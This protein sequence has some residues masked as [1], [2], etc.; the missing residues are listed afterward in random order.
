MSFHSLLVLLLLKL[1]IRAHASSSSNQQTNNAIVP[2][3]TK[4]TNLRQLQEDTQTPPTTLGVTLAGSVFYDFNQNGLRDSNEYG[5]PDVTIQIRNCANQRMGSTR[6]NAIGEYAVSLSTP[7]CYYARLDIT[8][9]TFTSGSNVDPLT[10][11]TGSVTLE[12]GAANF[13]YSSILPG[14]GIT[15]QPTGVPTVEQPPSPRPTVS[16]TT[17]SPTVRPSVS[18]TTAPPTLSP[19]IT[20]A[21]SGSPT[22]S[23][24]PTA[25][26]VK[27]PDAQNIMGSAPILRS[28]FGAIFSISTPTLSE[29]A[30]DVGMTESQLL[31][32]RE[33]SNPDAEYVRIKSLS[34][35]ALSS[36][37]SQASATNY[38]VW[39]IDGDYRDNSTATMDG[40]RQQQQQQQDEKFDA[41]GDLSQWTLIAEGNSMGSD[42]VPEEEEGG[43]ETRRRRRKL[44]DSDEEGVNS[45]E[46]GNSDT[47]TETTPLEV[48][49][50]NETDLYYQEPLT[51]DSNYF[52][53]AFPSDNAKYPSIPSSLRNDGGMETRNQ[54]GSSITTYLYQI[55]MSIFDAVE[56]PKYGGKA[57]F[58]VTLDRAVMQ[59]GDA[60]KDEWGMVDVSNDE[61]NARDVQ[62]MN[63]RI[64]VGEGVT[65]FPWSSI[66]NFY[67][68]RRFIGKVW[69]DQ[70]RHIPCLLHET[71]PSSSPT[72][73]V[74]PELPL[75]SDK[76][77]VGEDIETQFV[78]S[79]FLQQDL[80]DAGTMTP[81][82]QNVF[83]EV[84]VNF[85]NEE[86][87]YEYCVWGVSMDV[88][89]Q[90]LS[91]L[92]GVRRLRGRAKK[93]NK[94][95]MH[96]ELIEELLVK[97]RSLQMEI[98]VLEVEM[99]IEGVAYD[100]QSVCPEGA[101]PATAD[102]Y[103]K[104]WKE[105]MAIIGIDFVTDNSEKLGERLQDSHPFFEPIFAMAADP[106]MLKRP[107]SSKNPDDDEVEIKDHEDDE[108]GVPLVPIVAA[109]AGAVILLAL[110]CCYCYMRKKKQQKQQDDEPIPIDTPI[111][112]TPTPEVAKETSVAEDSIKKD[113]EM[114]PEQE[115][116]GDESIANTKSLDE[117]GSDS[118]LIPVFEDP[119]DAITQ[120]WPS[121][122]KVPE[123]EEVIMMRG[124]PRRRSEPNMATMEGLALGAMRRT[125]SISCLREIWTNLSKPLSYEDSDLAGGYINE[126]LT[127]G[128]YPI[129]DPDL[130][131]W[132]RE[133]HLIGDD[134]HS[135]YVPHGGSIEHCLIDEDEPAVRL[136]KL[137]MDS[138][139]KGGFEGKVKVN[140]LVMKQVALLESKWKELREEYDEDDDSDDE[141]DLDNFY[142]NDRIEQLM[143]HIEKLELERKLKLAELK[144]QEDE[145]EEL[146]RKRMVKGGTGI[147]YA[148][149]FN[150]ELVVKKKKKKR[151]SDDTLKNMILP[152]ANNNRSMMLMYVPFFF[153]HVCSLEGGRGRFGRS[154]F[155]IRIG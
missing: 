138:K 103:G 18:P 149:E 69:Y 153:F 114:A 144:R 56:I 54:G 60:A 133:K 63:V 96:H 23:S 9:H 14:D 61:Y 112:E 134:P 38:Q 90:K 64:H 46:D 113:P 34:L 19:T 11:R 62:D 33:E 51:L 88:R 28:S 117:N 126:L 111:I 87:V 137:E 95:Q 79:L 124:L 70:V 143:S 8:A 147:N 57:S 82:I 67:T 37:L 65:S 86:W 128:L 109:A 121:L 130:L 53:G 119:G 74:I 59:F 142:V 49:S 76:N 97:Q 120:A 2:H 104:D 44:Q 150:K 45:S 151:V 6:T 154:I 22:R 58:Y 83:K 131:M 15:L 48:I 52:S 84:M 7:G 136:E 25:C 116:E 106:E 27:E 68:P 94:H 71:A 145:D 99:N 146:A 40:S 50:S 108:G 105:T 12:D 135:P 66:M 129:D 55:P 43:E 13:W 72:D 5:V 101:I 155:R 77:I 93:N 24:S 141:N 102:T 81:D 4:V 115:V 148:Q 110:I 78:V 139:A 127:G 1:C 73:I 30:D 75:T 140:P 122:R 125:R 92:D 21:P 10:G 98:T 80:K 100:D 29:A 41:R 152:D 16:P 85:L 42:N 39:Y 132:E 26:E 107:A 3:D 123:L 118:G 36:L 31:A 91:L 35:R 20:G 17:A 32:S 89:F 47:V